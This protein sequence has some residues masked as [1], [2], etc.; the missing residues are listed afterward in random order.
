MS[1]TATVETPATIEP[2][3]WEAVK[4]LAIAVGVREAA[5]KCGLSENTVMARCRREGWLDMPG[6]REISNRRTREIQSLP[7]NAR[8]RMH[9]NAADGL[10]LSM[11]EDAMQGR[12]AALLAT[13]KAL[14]HMAHREPEELC[15]TE[16]ADVLS[17]HVRSASIAGGY[18]AAQRVDTVAEAFGG[19]GIEATVIDAEVI[20]SE[21]I[22]QGE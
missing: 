19:R 21:E 15:Q 20:E 13:R 8:T 17:K 5:R 12:A 16:A 14:V 18:G 1:D 22:E 4:V 11:R 3:N 2:V 9:A 7:V 10:L 6:A